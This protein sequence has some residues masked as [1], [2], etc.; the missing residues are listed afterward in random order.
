MFKRL[1]HFIVPAAITTAAAGLVIY[2]YALLRTADAMY[3]QTVLTYTMIPVGLLLV[4]FVEPPTRFWVSGD[5]FSGDWRPTLLVLGIFVLFLALFGF[6]MVRDLYDLV[7]LWNP[8]DYM[9]IGLVVI[10]WTFTLRFVWRLHLLDRYL[11]IDLGG[12]K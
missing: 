1:S 7:P 2:I 4:V 6:P 5:A 10:G 11:D 8:L 12:P 3:A 9:A